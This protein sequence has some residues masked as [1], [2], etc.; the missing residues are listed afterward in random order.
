M[1]KLWL[2]L[3]LVLISPALFL[4]GCGEEQALNS[5]ALVLTYD[6]ETKSAQGACAV[7]YV[8]IS[9]NAFDSV[10]FHLYSNAFSQE[11]EG[12][13]CSTSNEAK[14]YPNGK[15]YGGIEIT[16]V[17][18]GGSE[19]EYSVEGEA[20]MLLNVKLLQQLFPDERVKIEIDFVLTLPNANHRFGYGD[21]AVNFGNFYPIACVYEEGEGFM[22]EGY[23]ANGDPFYSN[24]ANYSVTVSYPKNF[25]IACSGDNLKTGENGQYLTTTFNANNV[26]DVSFVLSQNFNVVSAN[27]GDCQIDYYY[28]DDADPQGSL[29]TA[30]KAVQFYG[31]SFGEYPYSSLAVVQTNFVHGGMEYPRLVM[32]ADTVSGVDYDYVIAHEI[33][34][35][36][37]YGVVGNDEYHEAWLDESLTEFSTALFF[38]NYPEY[39][40]S[41]NQIISGAEENYK[42][43]LQIYDKIQ[44]EVDS[45]M[46]RAL[47]EF[48]TEPEYVNNIYTRGILLFDT[49]R[50]EIGDKKLLSTLKGYYKEFAYQNVSSSEFIAYFSSKAGRNLEKF[51]DSWL[52][53]KVEFVYA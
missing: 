27:S 39:N 16:S 9:N 12:L 51:F 25:K 17:K 34:H 22:D 7:D 11:G 3:C 41:Y 4:S 2:L 40:I 29:D 18:V 33:A 48:S 36:W 46:L 52:N 24:V 15:S 14:T 45:S 42:F 30:V 53:G 37:W 6:D 20:G 35:Q 44:G 1:K 43:F 23:I 49:L 32:I 10:L 5:Y 28:Y 19:A 47:N 50:S 21:N 31:E 26:R 38:E 8:N 13:V